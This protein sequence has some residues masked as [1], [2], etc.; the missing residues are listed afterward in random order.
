M[1]DT[2][3]LLEGNDRRRADLSNR[4]ECLSAHKFSC[5]SGGTKS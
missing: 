1:I 3:E 2:G 4:V 5:D